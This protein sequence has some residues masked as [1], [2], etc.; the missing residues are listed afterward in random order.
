M[1]SRGRSRRCSLL[2]YLTNIDAVPAIWWHGI[3]ACLVLAPNTT[4]SPA[5]KLLR[6]KACLRA[7][8][9]NSQLSGGIDLCCSTNAGGGGHQGGGREGQKR[10]GGRDHLS[11]MSTK[12]RPGFHEMLY[13]LPGR[14]IRVAACLHTHRGPWTKRTVG[15]EA[16][17][18]LL[19]AT[20]E[21]AA[22]ARTATWR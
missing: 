7:G 17:R 2:Y 19:S 16:P 3:H 1:L 4:N 20:G 11:D 8:S 21:A 10:E 13:Q 5:H 18:L 9:Q 22:A 6:R 14:Q 15:T 12:L